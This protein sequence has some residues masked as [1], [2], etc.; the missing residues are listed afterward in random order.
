MKGPSI[1]ELRDVLIFAIENQTFQQADVG[2]GIQ[3][4]ITQTISVR[5]KMTPSKPALLI[6]GVQLEM[7]VNAPTHTALIYTLPQ[8]DIFDIA[9]CDMYL[10]DGTIRREKHRVLGYAFIDDQR[11]FMRVDLQLETICP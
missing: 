7:D 2:T 9:Y 6:D 3:I 8:I 5:A 4:D 10:P 1:K 11:R